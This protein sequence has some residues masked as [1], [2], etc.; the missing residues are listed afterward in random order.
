ML[1]AT[2]D[3]HHPISPFGFWSLKV[4]Q[5]RDHVGDGLKHLRNRIAQFRID[6]TGQADKSWLHGISYGC[7]V[8]AGG[9]QVGNDK[10]FWVPLKHQKGTESMHLIPK[11][12][13]ENPHEARILDERQFFEELTRFVPEEA[14]LDTQHRIGRC[15]HTRTWR[16]VDRTRSGAPS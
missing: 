15:G 16:A 7:D 14:V 13:G 1:S 4:D 8:D 3:S 2:E 5:R 9:V 6:G 10:L 11:N 12:M